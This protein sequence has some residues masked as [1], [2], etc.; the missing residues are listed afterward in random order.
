MQKAQQSRHVANRSPGGLDAYW[1]KEKRLC[2]PSEVFKVD[3]NSNGRPV[4]FAKPNV[5][6]EVVLLQ[7]TNLVSKKTDKGKCCNNSLVE[8]WYLG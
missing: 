7:W 3:K 6:C 1:M 2:N 4:W 8:G 5:V